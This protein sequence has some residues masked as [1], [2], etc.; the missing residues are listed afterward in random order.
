M[1]PKLATKTFLP[2]LLSALIFGVSA[3]C[4]NAQPPTPDSGSGP[5]RMPVAPSASRPST[6]SSGPLQVLTDTRGVD[7][8]PYLKGVFVKIKRN[9]YSAIPEEARP[10]LLR[11]GSVVIGFKILK[12]G[13]VKDLDY[14][15]GSGFVSLDRAAYGGITTSAPFPPLPP[16]F[17]GDSLSLRFTFEYNSDSV[18]DSFQASVPPG[19]QVRLS[20]I[21]VSPQGCVHCESPVQMAAAHATCE[22]LLQQIHDG[23]K[24]EDVA[25]ANPSVARVVSDG[26]V[27][28]FSRGGIAKSIAEV[29]FS[30]KVGDVSPV[31]QTQQGCV[32]LKVTDH[33]GADDKASPATSIQ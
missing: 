3:W 12:N 11:K 19:E 27:G 4:Q 32:I 20:E 2:V 24:F 13:E 33:R 9:W 21:L 22:T 8:A 26:N 5:E 16:E 31:I 14:A 28:Y 29:V 10:P 30:M 1:S 17:T 7:F 25:R 15:K 23:A 18:A 6:A